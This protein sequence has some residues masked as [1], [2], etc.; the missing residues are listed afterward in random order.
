MRKA[1]TSLVFFLVVLGI[2]F[3]TS[4]S[5]TD[6]IL[7]LGTWNV[8]GYPETTSER[9]AWFSDQLRA[10]GIQVLCIQEIANQAKVDSFIS[11]EE[12]FSAAAFKNSSDGQDN[13]VFFS[14]GIEI[15]DVSDPEGFQHPAQAVY[16][17]YYGLDAMLITVH[18]AWTDTAQ[19]ANERTL[20]VDIV[21]QALEVD[22]DVILAGDFNTTEKSGDTI[23]G[24]ADSL[25]LNILMPDNSS[26]GTTYAGKNYDYILVSPDLYTEEAL[27]DSRIIVFDDEQIASEVSD[28]RPVIA[29]FRT[30][31]AYSDWSLNIQEPFAT[32]P[33]AASVMALEAQVS[34]LCETIDD[35]RHDIED[36]EDEVEELKDRVEDL[37]DQLE[38][39]ED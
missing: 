22:P 1:V 6:E 39:I 34:E 24:L 30:D 8:R 9:A 35:L 31:L 13:A 11:T 5:S 28:H 26:I 37:E 25:G 33:D 27:D 23:A 20:L 7:V 3:A 32:P 10:M 36:L 4:A 18:L 2:V 16:F 29:G 17:R 12:G 15:L 38:T 19:R 21:K 14:N